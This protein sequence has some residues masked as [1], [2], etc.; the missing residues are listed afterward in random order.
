KGRK[1]RNDLQVVGVGPTTGNLIGEVPEGELVTNGGI[2]HGDSGGPLFDNQG[3]IAG[4]ASRVSARAKNCV[5]ERGEEAI[6]GIPAAHSD[7]IQQ[8]ATESGHSLGSDPSTKRPQQA[9]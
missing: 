3:Q 1:Q 6:Y 8:A 9:P 4:V 7:L 5:D 2:C